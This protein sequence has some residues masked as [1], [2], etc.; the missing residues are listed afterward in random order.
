MGNP[1]KAVKKN[2]EVALEVDGQTYRLVFDLDAMEALS[3]VY[4][5]DGEEGNWM[6]ILAKVQK[7]SI[8]AIR[9]LV[10]SMFVQHHPDI[11]LEDSKRIIAA[12]GGVNI[13]GALINAAFMSATPDQ[14]DM[15][16]MGVGR[17]KKGNP[18]GAQ[19]DGDGTGDKSELTPV[20]S[21]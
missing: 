11:T 5:K 14:Q 3:D 9:A 20:A 17:G 13:V 6:D 2:G 19:D 21:A 10:W 4:S 7:Q 8:K 15:K 18:R 16:A 12:A 1:I